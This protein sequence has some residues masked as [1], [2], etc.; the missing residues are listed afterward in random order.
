MKINSKR[1]VVL[2][3]VAGMCYSLH[4]QRG[5]TLDIRRGESG[6][7]EFAKFARNPN[8][9]RKMANDTIFLKSILLAKPEDGFRL[10]SEIT[11]E[12]G[13]THKRFQTVLQGNQSGKC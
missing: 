2:L 5:D 9:D 6:K 8:S 12:L 13:I 4:A 11:D 1:T 10:I 7:I 3:M